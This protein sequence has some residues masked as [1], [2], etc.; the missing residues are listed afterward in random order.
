MPNQLP[1]AEELLKP[2]PS[3]QA[4]ITLAAAPPHQAAAI[5]A[6]LVRR[7][8]KFDAA[9]QKHSGEWIIQVRG[10]LL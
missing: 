9:E 1:D 6:E 5:L 4:T 10:Y 7:G 8:I 2:L 3:C